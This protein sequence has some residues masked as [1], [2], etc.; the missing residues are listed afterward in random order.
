MKADHKDIYEIY[1]KNVP[2]IVNTATVR[3]LEITYEK[4]NI[5]GD[6]SSENY[7]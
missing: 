7:A 4:C 6:Y 5:A 1:V 3:N 2:I